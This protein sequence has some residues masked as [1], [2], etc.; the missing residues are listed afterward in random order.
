MG[1]MKNIILTGATGGIGSVIAEELG[2]HGYNLI[3]SSRDENRLLSL[4]NKLQQHIK[5]EIS[6]LTVDYSDTN[7]FRQFE[8]L[9]ETKR[10]IDGLVLI[11]PKPVTE[12]HLFPKKEEW[13]LLFNTT[14]I[15]PLLLIESVLPFMRHGQSKIVVISGIA[16]KQYMPGKASFS[17]IR[18]AWLA[19]AKAL[20]YELGPAGISVNTISPGGVMTEASV[21]RMSARAEKAGL[22]FDQQY[23]SSVSNVPLRK[24]A[25]PKEVAAIVRFFL[26]EQ[27]NHI[28]GEN[29]VCDG[30]FNRGY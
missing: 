10:H 13:Q 29:I 30:G 21:Q 4:K 26:S 11:T 8:I 12:S 25:S 27:S 18:N 2:S 17:V 5:S 6:C 1:H 16:S 24:Y 9:N 20:A 3:L 7:T 14:F 19:Q 23:A 22:T 28:T 15:G